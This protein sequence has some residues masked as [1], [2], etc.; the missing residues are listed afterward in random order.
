MGGSSH[1]TSRTTN[2]TTQSSQ[3]SSICA[4]TT[5]VQRPTKKKV[6]R[7]YSFASFAAATGGNRKPTTGFGVYSDPTTAAQPYY[8]LTLSYTLFLLLQPGT[9]SK[10]IL[11]GPMKLKSASPT[12]IDIGFKPCGLK[13]KIKDTVSTSQLQQMKANKKNKGSCEPPRSS[14]FGNLL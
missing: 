4:G 6:Q 9:S 3:P 14:S 11:H 13:W 7:P 8:D 10:K 1:S 12:N 5:V 2:A